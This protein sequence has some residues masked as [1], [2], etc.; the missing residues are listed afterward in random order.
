[1]DNII[2]VQTQAIKSIFSTMQRGNIATTLFRMV[3]HC[4]NA[5]CVALKIVV[6][7]SPEIS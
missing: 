6:A 1:M 2:S 7:N 4:S 3:T 5:V